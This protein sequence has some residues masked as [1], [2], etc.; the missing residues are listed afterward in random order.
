VGIEL[1]V[2]QGGGVEAP[3]TG[4]DLASLSIVRGQ[5]VQLLGLHGLD[6]I[7]PVQRKNRQGEGS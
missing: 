6:L 5:F 3:H 7:H 4:Q 2:Y 1:Q